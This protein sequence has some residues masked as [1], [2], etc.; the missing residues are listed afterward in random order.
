MVETACTIHT[1]VVTPFQ[2]NARI[3]HPV[4][5]CEAVIVDPG[6]EADLILRELEKFG[7]SLSAV[8]LTHS[9]LDHCG[10]VAAILERYPVPLFGHR[11]EAEMRAHVVDICEMYGLPP[12]D[13]QN[14][15]EPDQYLEEGQR[16]SVGTEQFE[17]FFTP[18]HSPG[19]VVLY[20][21]GDGVLLAGDTVFAGSIGRTDLPG[22][23][24]ETL[25]ESIRAKVLS[26]PDET[27]IL[28]GHG[29]ETTVGRER[30]SNPWLQ[31]R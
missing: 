21:A 15:P 12:G 30:K 14:C 5:S 29:P 16:I 19:H 9:H 22:G 11:V 13:M 26:L 10:G 3:V 8:W 6:G 23:D 20:H 28:C 4:G 25:L 27:R 17:V 2:Q 7:L 31:G 1:L 24:H 18:G